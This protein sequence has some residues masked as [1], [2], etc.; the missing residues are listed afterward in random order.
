MVIPLDDVSD[1]LATVSLRGYLRSV[2]ADHRRARITRQG[3]GRLIEYMG[4]RS[5]DCAQS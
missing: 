2:C 1:P 3:S 5:P 4:T